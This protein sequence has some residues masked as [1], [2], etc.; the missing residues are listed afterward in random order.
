MNRQYAV[1]NNI[2][3]S[4]SSLVSLYLKILN[5]Y[6]TCSEYIKLEKCDEFRFEQGF[7]SVS[8]YRIEESRKVPIVHLF[9]NIFA[10]YSESANLSPKEFLSILR[11]TPCGFSGR[12]FAIYGD[13]VNIER[14]YLWYKLL[15]SLDTLCKSL[16]SDSNYGYTI[17]PTNLRAQLDTIISRM[18]STINDKPTT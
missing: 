3:F 14:I 10:S 13:I 5:R 9:T 11:S 7:Q 12:I 17:S 18:E 8:V 16:S 6:M 15:N 4:K 2:V 1:I